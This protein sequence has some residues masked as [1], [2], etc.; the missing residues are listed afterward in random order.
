MT[1]QSDKKKLPIA[2][3]IRL[4]IA[5][6][7]V[8]LVGNPNA[9]K[10]TVFNALTGLR[11]KVANYPGVTVEK[12]IGILQGI[13]GLKAEIHD[14]PGIYSLSPESIDEQIAVNEILT[15]SSDINISDRV[16]VI[17]IVADATNLERNLYLC[18]QILD[19]G[20]PTVVVLNMMDEAKRNDIHIDISGLSKMLGVPVVATSAKK[21]EGIESLRAEI[22]SAFHKKDTPQDGY[23]QIPK[24]IAEASKST[25]LWMQA[26]AFKSE[27]AAYAETLRIVA[28]D[29]ELKRWQHHLRYNSLIK[30]V[31]QAREALVTNHIPWSQTEVQ[32]RYTWVDQ[33]IFKNVKQGSKDRLARS[34]KID[35]VL[36]SKIFGPTIFLG[37]LALIFQTV[38]TWSEIPMN[39]IENIFAMLNEIV[40]SVMPDGVLEDL[41]IN[42]ALTGVGAIVIFLPQILLLFFFLAILED[43]GYLARAAFMLDRIMSK[44]GLQG[45]SVIPLLSSFA[46]A[47]PGIMA[48][49]TI[50]NPHDRLVTILVAPLMS[51]SARLPVYALMI[52]A[53]I[54]QTSVLV[55]FSLQGLTLLTMYLIGI[56]MAVTAALI[57]RRFV[58]QGES[59]AFMMEL[60]IYQLP[61]WRSI[62]WQ[63]YERAKLFVLNAGKIILAISIVLWFLVSYPK[64]ES[65][66]INKSERT[67]TKDNKNPILQSYA[68]RLGKAIEPVIEPL[69][70]D[71]KIGIGLITS[72]AA[73]EVM[74]STLATIYNVENADEH[75]IDLKQALLEDRHPESGKPVYT[76]LVALS[77][78]VFFVLAC[79]CMSTVAIVKRETDTWRWPIFMVAYMTCLA[80]LSSLLV[81]QGGKFL[82]LG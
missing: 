43:T 72:F 58:V 9:G 68:G 51:C 6:G 66:E 75:S 63:M 82:G 22:F 41:V 33:L 46:C 76:P 37:I 4:R 28:N 50:K 54:P 26:N 5:A 13:G 7:R 24:V 25:A 32:A 23:W 62:L 18:A 73:R 16:D 19:Q 36:T 15:Q 8:L 74:V 14:L 78:M 55:I 79:Q 31:K 1:T 48:A 56:V 38:F 44:I 42:G 69:G 67:I 20:N 35:R 39:A 57:I 49:R 64:V 53:F 2:D 11:Q 80:Y 40:A 29:L 27:R 12:K 34:E 59:K 52:A 30:H 77:L 71:W 70:F 17:V 21:K 10:T 47:I 3:Q 61:S 45:H 60:P 65:S 81:Y